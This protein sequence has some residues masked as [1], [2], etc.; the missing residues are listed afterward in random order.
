MADIYSKIK[1]LGEQFSNEGQ[2]IPSNIISW[3]RDYKDA[4]IFVHLLQFDGMKKFL[5]VLKDDIEHINSKLAG[6]RTL[7]TEERQYLF[8]EKD[9][10]YSIIQ[11]FNT[12]EK[13][14]TDLNKR[15][16]EELSE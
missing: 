3:G 8:G 6:D 2:E 5:A 14:L 10:K 13:L 9:A 11:F 1:K 15:V 4:E 16:D 7:N 12:K